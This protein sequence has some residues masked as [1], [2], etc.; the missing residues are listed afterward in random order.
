MSP[1][2]SRTRRTGGDQFRTTNWAPVRSTALSER[3]QAVDPGGVHERD[4]AEVELEELPAGKLGQ[5]TVVIDDMLGN[6]VA[7]AEPPHGEAV[8]SA[9]SDG[10]ELV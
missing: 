4:L 10:P 2:S 6:G 8:S 5:G 1:V 9:I 7:V 3:E